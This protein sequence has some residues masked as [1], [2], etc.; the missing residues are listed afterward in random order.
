[1]SLLLVS[2][3]NLRFSVLL[4]LQL[5]TEKLVSAMTCN[6]I[7]SG[8][9]VWQRLMLN[10]QPNVHVPV[11]SDHSKDPSVK[12]ANV[13]ILQTLIGVSRPFLR[14][15][16][17]DEVGRVD[18]TCPGVTQCHITAQLSHLHL[19]QLQCCSELEQRVRWMQP[20]QTHTALQRD[21]SQQPEAFS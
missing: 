12:Y 11:R 4:Q 10:K 5:W 21:L 18:V 9:A 19:C 1:M 14:P 20:L 13:C 8:Y 6:K 16:D 3:F 7:L 2:E 17:A 15:G